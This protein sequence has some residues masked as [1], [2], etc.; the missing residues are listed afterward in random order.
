M[1]DLYNVYVKRIGSVINNFDWNWV[2][3]LTLSL[4]QAW[5]KGNIVFCVVMGVVQAMQSI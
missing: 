1:L 5:R 2:H 4:Q 3:Q